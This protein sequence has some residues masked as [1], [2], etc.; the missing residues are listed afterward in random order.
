VISLSLMK[1][2]TTRKTHQGFV[3][4]NPIEVIKGIGSGIA[5][6]ALNNLGRQGIN[7]LWEQML[8]ADTSKDETSGDLKEGEEIILKSKKETPFKE[9]G[10]NY[11]REIIDAERVSTREN[12]RVI[13]SKIQEILV[14]LK[15]LSQTSAEIAM[16]FKEITVEQRIEKPGE[17]HISFFQWMLSLVKAA[18][19]KIEDSGAWL[20]VMRSKKAQRNYWAMFRKHGTT[21][22][23]SNERVVATQTG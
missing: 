9:S 8:G 19:V 12:Q 18:R 2:K 13:Q 16:E 23:L 17:Y 4:Q 7:Q 21:F 1:G 14:E 5:D 11:R 3:D 20:K 22:G 15:K 10:L 6:S